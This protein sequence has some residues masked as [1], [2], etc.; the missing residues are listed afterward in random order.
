MLVQFAFFSGYFLFALPSGKIIE[1][2]GYKRSMV[3]GLLTIALGAILFL[4]AASLASFPFFLTALMIVA[5][6]ITLLQVS[7]NPYVSVL[8]PPQTA[9]SR[10]N[11]TQAFNSL[12]TTVAPYFGSLLILSNTTLAESLLLL[13][14]KRIGCRK[15]PRLNSPTC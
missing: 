8:G 15:L 3:A 9:S 11:L 4:P 7:A 6:G 2:I 10:L 14:C 12:G 13:P 1:K 5:A